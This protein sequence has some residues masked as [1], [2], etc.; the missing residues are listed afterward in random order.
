MKAVN[1]TKEPAAPK[2][3]LRNLAADPAAA[4]GQPMG[5]PFTEVKAEA[6]PLFTWTRVPPSAPAAAPSEW[7]PA[8]GSGGVCSDPTPSTPTAAPTGNPFQWGPSGDTVS[9][10][11]PGTAARAPAAAPKVG[12]FHWG[13]RGGSRAPAGGATPQSAGPGDQP[14]APKECPEEG[15]DGPGWEGKDGAQ[16]QAEEGRSEGGGEDADDDD[17]VSEEV[18]EREREFNDPADGPDDY[19]VYKVRL[20]S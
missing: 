5:D 1:E 7:V 4:A 20:T 3:A 8:E 9:N 17:D 19:P 10:P 15:V 2:M 12:P 18:P 13:M 16:G 6:P 14:A 11:A